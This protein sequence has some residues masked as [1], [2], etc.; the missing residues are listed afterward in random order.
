MTECMTKDEV[1]FTCGSE[2]TP[3]PT[4]WLWEG[5]LPLG[6]L[7]VLAGA[8]GTGKTSVAIDLGARLSV[9]SPW[10]DGSPARVG[11]VLILSSEDDFRDTLLP[12]FIAAGGDR[13][14]FHTIGDVVGPKGRRSFDAREDIARLDE[15]FAKHPGPTILIVDPITS[16]VGGD[17]HKN[18]QVRHSLQPLL[19]LAERRGCAVLGITHFT[20]GT[21]G[22]DPLERVTGSLAFGAV[23]RVVLVAAKNH[24]TEGPPRVLARAKVSIGADGGG[25]AY[26]VEEAR[27]VE[28]VEITT[29]KIKWGE[30][31]DGSAR[32]IVAMVEATSEEVSREGAVVRWLRDF[33]ADPRTAEDTE[34]AGKAEG[35]SKTTI[36]R[37]CKK[38]GVVKKK[39]GMGGGWHW[40]LPSADS[41]VAATSEDSEDPEGLKPQLLES[42]VSSASTKEFE[43]RTERAAIMEFDERLTRS[44]AEKR[45]SGPKPAAAYFRAW[46]NNGTR[47]TEVQ[48]DSPNSL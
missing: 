43:A 31:L 1:I 7:A 30:R 39:Q 21:T 45:A 38:L 6:K 20:K 41:V 24:G 22:A 48:S 23:P 8:A 17:D 37:A 12:R 25:F 15:F 16:V 44:E 47:V 34:K 42:S 40:S 36:W 35:Y 9:G 4:L 19:H 10:P 46:R 11:T 14:R 32:A 28:P 29:S 27:I 18:A 13:T 5:Y 2:V 33:L 3:S 26:A